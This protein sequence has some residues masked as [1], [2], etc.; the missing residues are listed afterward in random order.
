MALALMPMVGCM[1]G[2][3]QIDRAIVPFPPHQ[4]HKCPNPPPSGTTD[5]CYPS[6]YGQCE[7]CISYKCWDRSW[8]YRYCSDARTFDTAPAVLHVS[9]LRAPALTLWCCVCVSRVASVVH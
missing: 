7:A 1:C 4:V 6:S 5:P 8:R 9:R 2:H 3:A